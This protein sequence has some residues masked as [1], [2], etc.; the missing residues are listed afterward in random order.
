MRSDRVRQHY[1]LLT[2][3]QTGTSLIWNNARGYLLEGELAPGGR[4][5]LCWNCWLT[6]WSRNATCVNY[7]PA[8]AGIGTQA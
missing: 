5:S 8:A 3:G 1:A 7:T 2:H 4:L 6:P